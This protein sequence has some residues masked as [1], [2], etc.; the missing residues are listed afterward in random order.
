MAQLRL[1]AGLREA[2]GASSVSVP[3]STVAELLANAAGEYGPTFE[4]GLSHARVWVNGEPATSDTTVADG[5]EVALIPPVSGGAMAVVEVPLTMKALLDLSR[6][7]D[8]K[9]AWDELE[10]WIQEAR[11]EGR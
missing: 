10:R 9:I 4:A 1:F 8:R 3:G 7:R 2:A 5:D 11:E 6:E